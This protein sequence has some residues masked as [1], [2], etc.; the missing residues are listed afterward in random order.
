MS[1]NLFDLLKVIK[2]Q[3]G[4]E[5]MFKFNKKEVKIGIWKKI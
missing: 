3:W 4:E 1:G 2:K 5:E